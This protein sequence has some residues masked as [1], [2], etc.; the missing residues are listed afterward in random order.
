MISE[1]SKNCIL[2]EVGS[3]KCLILMKSKQL[4]WWVDYTRVDS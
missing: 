1:H 2:S 4:G 3:M